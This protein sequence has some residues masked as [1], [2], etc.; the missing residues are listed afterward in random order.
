MLGSHDRD[1]LLLAH[2]NNIT[3]RCLAPTVTYRP[4]PVRRGRA[5]S[6]SRNARFAALIG[7]SIPDGFTV[8]GAGTSFRLGPVK[9]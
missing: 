6:L 4:P 5:T 1:L 3:S 2:C 7:G 8:S 9:P